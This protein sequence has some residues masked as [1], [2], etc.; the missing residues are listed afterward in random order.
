MSSPASIPISL[1]EPHKHCES[2]HNQDCACIEI[3][4][5]LII[6]F[7]ESPIPC[8]ARTPSVWVNFPPEDEVVVFGQAVFQLYLLTLEE[9]F[10]LLHS[11]FGIRVVNE[12][13]GFD[14]FHMIPYS[15][16]SPQQLKPCRLSQRCLG[17]MSILEPV[18][19]EIT[20]EH[21]VH[22]VFHRI[23]FQVNRVNSE[24]FKPFGLLSFRLLCFLCLF[25]AQK[26][27]FYFL[28]NVIY[29]VFEVLFWLKGFDNNLTYFIDDDKCC[30]L[31]RF[32]SLFDWVLQSTYSAFKRFNWGRLDLL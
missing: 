10:P 16:I 12:L 18:H 32:K 6:C 19:I 30:L 22:S 2:S 5:T 9:V 21:Q 13:V 28:F 27:V 7:S 3:E 25:F 15:N 20:K 29:K 17:Q 14:H 24:S 26:E 23:F 11:F 1:N 31:N 8:E 4:H